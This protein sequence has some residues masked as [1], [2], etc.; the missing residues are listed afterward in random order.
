MLLPSSVPRSGPAR[1]PRQVDRNGVLPGHA[2]TVRCCGVEEAT[3]RRGRTGR[4]RRPRQEPEVRHR[5]PRVDQVR[6]GVALPGEQIVG[7]V[8]EVGPLEVRTSVIAI[9][10]RRGAPDAGA[11]RFHALERES[12]RFRRI[13]EIPCPV[14]TRGI[15]AKYEAGLLTIT[16]PKI[17][18]RR[19]ERRKVPIESVTTKPARARRT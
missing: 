14:D 8:S 11:V 6:R 16:L 1:V 12:G 3:A 10:R 7:R 17:E 4:N 2:A 13:L 18:D 19:G 15:R 9:R 5:R